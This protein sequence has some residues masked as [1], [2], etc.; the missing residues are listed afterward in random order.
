MDI[1][2]Y[3]EDVAIEYPR[4]VSSRLAKGGI[5]N[6]SCGYAYEIDDPEI[7]RQ[8]GNFQEGYVPYGHIYRTL[9]HAGG[10]RDLFAHEG[11]KCGTK[12]VIPFS[13]IMDSK[14]GECL[15]KSILVQLAAQ[16]GRESFLIKG[17]LEQNCEAGNDYHAYNVVFKE[18]APFLVD[19]QNPIINDT[20]VIPYIAPILSIEKGTFKVPKEWQAGRNYCLA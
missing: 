9:R 14:I 6:K 15:E 13:K 18:G 17:V 4:I 1:K 2:Q 10:I 8:L 11:K 7:F 16:K 5:V 3:L 20:E 12:L 19:A